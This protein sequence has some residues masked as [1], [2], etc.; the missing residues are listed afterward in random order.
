MKRWSAQHPA[1][2]PTYVELAELYDKLN[3]P[4]LARSALERG[5]SACPDELSLAFRAREISPDEQVT[6]S[7]ATPIRAISSDS[8]PTRFC[9]RMARPNGT[10][11][12]GSKVQTRRGRG[13]ASQGHP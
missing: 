11:V 2:A 3:Q 6:D 1:F 13:A 10:C 8:G 7:P 12:A 4:G 5:A 9:S